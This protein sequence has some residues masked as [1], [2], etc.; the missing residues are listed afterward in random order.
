MQ[1]GWIGGPSRRDALS[2]NPGTLGCSTFKCSASDR[3]IRPVFLLHTVY[4]L[5]SCLPLH[6]SYVDAY[7]QT[8]MYTTSSTMCPIDETGARRSFSRSRSPILR[9]K[10]L[11]TL[12]IPSQI[13][14]T[15]AY[16]GRTFPT[17][18]ILKVG[19]HI[20]SL[21]DV[22][23]ISLTVCRYPFTHL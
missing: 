2:S 10:Q 5:G 11:F 14:P 20:S 15:P 12:G 13:H 3:Y 1:H 9:I 7:S 6:I 17:E 18:L 22:L 21:R 19:Q 8:L 23:S 4:T 16:H